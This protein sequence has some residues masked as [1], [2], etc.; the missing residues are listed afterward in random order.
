MDTPGMKT[1]QQGPQEA[2][3]GEPE[4]QPDSEH[5][6]LF[7]AY[8]RGGIQ[9]QRVHDGPRSTKATPGPEARKTPKLALPPP[10]PQGLLPSPPPG[11][12]VPRTHV[13]MRT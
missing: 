1:Q 6:L 10:L 12:R 7:T 4:S 9:V 11:I 13:R 2:V 8:H 5:V 3:P